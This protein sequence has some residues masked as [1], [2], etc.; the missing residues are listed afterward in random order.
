MADLKKIEIKTYRIIYELID[1][2]KKMIRGS[3]GPV[4]EDKIIGKVEVRMIIPVPRSGGNIAGSY[5]LEGKVVRNAKV[6]V[7][8]KNREIH[9]GVIS[10]LK[11]FKDDAR[12][13][14]QGYECGINV[15][16]FDEYEVGDILEISETV[17]V[18]A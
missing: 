11:R 12:E 1:D 16:N 4:F 7:M 6:K 9:R 17:E 3:T 8:R 13:V 18:T 15:S 14:L 10:G 2:V 5:V